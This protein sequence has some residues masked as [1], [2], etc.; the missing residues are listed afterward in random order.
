M[1]LKFLKA[2]LVMGGILSYENLPGLR[3]DGGTYTGFG[4][5]AD[6]LDPVDEGEGRT[7]RLL[8]RIFPS[9]QRLLYLQ[10]RGQASG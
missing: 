8:P 2:F 10:I 4:Y 3:Q 7:W 5:L 9:S 1:P 6:K